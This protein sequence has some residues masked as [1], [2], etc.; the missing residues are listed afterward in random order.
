MISVD[1]Q[2]RSFPADVCKQQK[3]DGGV[4]SAI[5]LRWKEIYSEIVLWG[6]IRNHSQLQNKNHK[7]YPHFQL[8]TLLSYNNI[9]RIRNLS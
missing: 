2:E 5:Q 7:Q 8:N 6:L 4:I 1:P 9:T 3:W